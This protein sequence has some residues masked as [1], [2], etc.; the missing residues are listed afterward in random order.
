RDVLDAVQTSVNPKVIDVPGGS[1][2]MA[3]VDGVAGNGIQLKVKARVTVRT[4]LDRLVG[5]ASENTIIAR[6][7]QGIV[8][9]IGASKSHMEVLENPK[10]IS[11]TV[12]DSGL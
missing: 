11:K 9:T 2:G 10:S 4:N 3:T 12:L 7:G 1:S 8:S 5:G 6:V